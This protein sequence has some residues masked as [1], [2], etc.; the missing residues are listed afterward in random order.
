M[1]A[2]ELIV[3][4]YVRLRDREA[5]VELKAHREDLL[6]QLKAREGGWF[7]VS[8]TIGRIEQDIGQIG[9]GLAQLDATPGPPTFP[10]LQSGLA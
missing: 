6:A 3:D 4:G 1:M 10:N 5:L 7:D 2:I 9:D 8:R